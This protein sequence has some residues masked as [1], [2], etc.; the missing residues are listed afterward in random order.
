MG[1]P[2]TGIE[3]QCRL[4]TNFFKRLKIGKFAGW[5]VYTEPHAGLQC[6]LVKTV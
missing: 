4:E 6:F 5:R 3:E 1:S 2:K